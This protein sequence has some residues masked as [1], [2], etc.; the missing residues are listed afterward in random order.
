MPAPIYDARTLL[1]GAH[2]NQ[3]KLDACTD[4]DFIPEQPG[5]QPHARRLVCRHCAGTV[6]AHAHHWYQKG[7]D[8]AKLAA[9][10]Q[11]AKAA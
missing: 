2:S 6:D 9:K 10:R 5:E 11:N 3:I 4:H 8:H 7:R 1:A